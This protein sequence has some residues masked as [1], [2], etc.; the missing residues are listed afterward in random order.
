[1][2]TTKE[3]EIIIYKSKDGP[4]EDVCIKDETNWLTQSEMGELFEKVYR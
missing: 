4:S 1:M 3:N 2:K